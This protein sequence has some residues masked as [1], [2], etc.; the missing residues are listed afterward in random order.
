MRNSCLL[1]LLL[2]FTA[3]ISSLCIAHGVPATS[4]TLQDDDWYDN[5]NIDRNYYGGRNGY[6][7]N[8][9]YETLNENREL[10]F[11]IGETFAANYAS[12]TARAEA[13]LNYVQTWTEYGYDDENVFRDG[14]PQ[15]EWAWN[16][17]EMAHNFNETTGVV[18]IGDCEDLAFLCGTIYTGAGFDAAVVDCTDHVGCLIWLPEYPN[19]E[20]YWDIPD[21]SRGAGWIWVESTGGANP[22]GWTPPDYESGD[23]TA[24]PLGALGPVTEPSQ[25]PFVFD[26]PIDTIIVIAIIL[27]AVIVIVAGASAAG[28]RR[29]PPPPS[30]Y[31]PPPPQQ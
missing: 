26:L 4:F 8:I 6:L 15:P 21:D 24:Y 10:A 16:A 11:S 1:L 30:G 28:R 22:L 2:L 23:W 31:W 13:I 17:D 3:P 18:A 9:A 20:I 19:A 25:I 5:W 7:P 12:T 27:F 14:E 29:S